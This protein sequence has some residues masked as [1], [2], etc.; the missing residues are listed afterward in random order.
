LRKHPAPAAS[1]RLILR[2]ARKR[3]VSKDEA[4]MSV[5]SRFETRCC[6]ALLSVRV[7]SDCADNAQ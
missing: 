6:A 1:L 5:A 4:A 7:T 2:A 3:G